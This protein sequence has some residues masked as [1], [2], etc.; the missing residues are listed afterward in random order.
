MVSVELNVLPSGRKLN[1]YKTRNLHRNPFHTV[2]L[3]F[4]AVKNGLHF[5]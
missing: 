3:H 2:N 4:R 5:R 1:A